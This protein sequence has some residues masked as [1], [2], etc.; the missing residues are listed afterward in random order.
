MNDQNQGAAAEQPITASVADLQA[1]VEEERRRG[2][3]LLSA[4]QRERAD[5]QNF[6]RRTEERRQAD[7]LYANL[8]LVGNLL[9]VLDDLDRA[10][11]ASDGTASQEGLRAIARKFAGALEASGVREIPAAGQPFDPAVHE[12]VAQIPGDQDTVLHVQDKGYMMGDRVIRP[13]RVIVGSGLPAS[14]PA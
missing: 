3:E 2:L 14:E 9:P 10:V 6:K 5:F 11:A 1:Q 13:A 8:A 7:A 4:W 12:S